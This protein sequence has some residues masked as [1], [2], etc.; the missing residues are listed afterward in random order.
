MEQVVLVRSCEPDGSAKVLH[1]R[2]SA[3]SGDCHQC[4]GCGAAQEKMF[5]TVRNPINAK[6][7][8]LVTIQAE[9]GPVLLAA[10]VL[11]IVPLILFFT[12]YGFFS[13]LGGG[14]GF[15]LGIVLAVLYDRLILKKKKTVYTIIGYARNNREE[16]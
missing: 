3:C 5:L 8:D 1:I 13:G 6:P 16:P 14:L 7:G 10:V 12:G 4:T 2:K 11:Y 15:A 9:S